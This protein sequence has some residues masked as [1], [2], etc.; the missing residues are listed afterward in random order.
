MSFD[1]REHPSGPIR[2]A[3]PLLLAA[4]RFVFD[5]DGRLEPDMPMVWIAAPEAREC[6]VDALT[7]SRI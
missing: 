4:D 5:F 3:L 7:E 6:V 1:V 2:A